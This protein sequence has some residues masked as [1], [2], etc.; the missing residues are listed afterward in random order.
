MSSPIPILRDKIIARLATVA[1]ITATHEGRP[2]GRMSGNLLAKGPRAWAYFRREDF[3][4]VAKGTS[5]RALKCLAD[6]VVEVWAI[7]PATEP[8]AARDSSAL[9]DLLDELSLDAKKAI[10]TDVRLENTCLM[11]TVTEREVDI[12]G[13]TDTEMGAA[14]LVVQVCYIST[15]GD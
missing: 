15:E 8:D 11:C 14:L 6:F 7:A 5:G 10:E 3:Q 2:S 9:E 4:P 13:S 12:D 1:A